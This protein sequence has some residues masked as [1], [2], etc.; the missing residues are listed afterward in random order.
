MV[1]DSQP[2]AT[3]L[4]VGES[5]VDVDIDTATNYI[6]TETAKLKDLLTKYETEF[7]RIETRQGELKKILY[8]RFGNSINLEDGTE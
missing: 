8:A 6:T 7:K 3:K 4:M 1:D 5:F 2:G